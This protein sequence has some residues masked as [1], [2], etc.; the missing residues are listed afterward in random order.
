MAEALSWVLD[1]PY[2]CDDCGKEFRLGDLR[3]SHKHL[4]CK[5]CA[6]GEKNEEGTD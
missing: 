5:S 2:D 6:E 4:Y 1:E 3:G